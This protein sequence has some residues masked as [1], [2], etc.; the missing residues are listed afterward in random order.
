MTTRNYQITGMSCNHCVNRVK[1]A[2]EE[3]D[4]V[5]TAEVTLNP[6]VARL[7]L[8]QDISQD[9]LSAAIEEAGAYSIIAKD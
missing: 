4:E 1:M 6:P 8:K 7:Q 3:L 9:R 5:Q 2:F